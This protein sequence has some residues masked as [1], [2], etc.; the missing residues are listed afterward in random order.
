M[1]GLDHRICNIHDPFGNLVIVY[2]LKTYFLGVFCIRSR[3][4]H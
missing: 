2:D 1:L 3:V 4:L